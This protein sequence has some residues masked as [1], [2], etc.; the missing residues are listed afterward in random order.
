MTST[1]LDAQDQARPGRSDRKGLFDQFMRY[2]FFL[3]V[4]VVFAV[5][6]WLR[7]TFVSAGN[8]NGMLVSVSIAS[9]M[10]LGLT[11][12]IAAGEND[13]SFMSIAALANMIAAGL[14]TTGTDWPL[15]LLAG[16]AAGL[17]L[18]LLNGYLVAIL[19]INSLVVT[20][21]SGSL[22]ASLA[23]AIGT[24]SSIPLS[25]SG[26]F[27]VVFDQGLGPVPLI[28]LIVGL[29]YA[30]AWYGQEKLAFGRYIYAMEQNR[31][32]VVEA[33]VPTGKLLLSLYVL[34]GFVSA[35]AGLAVVANLN[36]GQPYLGNSYFFEGLTAAFLG[37]A[38]LK[39]GKANVIGTL[40]AVI[41]LTGMLNAAAL[42]GWTD[43][44]RQLVRGALLLVGVSLVVFARWYAKRLHRS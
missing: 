8:I 24:G 22:A 25:S 29:I 18:G 37:G 14:V 11:W 15:A 4:I 19:K 20:I 10:F 13:V 17:A 41:F 2:G 36:S 1:L 32:A 3:L 44:Q 28:A 9:L 43:S 5:F 30:V 27:G 34:S 40:A 7:P 39:L 38:A 23:A 26:P 42:L 31:E 35:L 6:A 12:I 16:L 21:A 33:G